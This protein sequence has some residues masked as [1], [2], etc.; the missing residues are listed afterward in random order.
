MNDTHRQFEP[1]TL[2]TLPGGDAGRELRKLHSRSKPMRAKHMTI[3]G[4]LLCVLAPPAWTQSLEI[5]SEQ[6]Y[7]LL[8][9]RQTSTMQYELAEA[10]AEG[11]RVVAGSPISHKEMALLLER[12]AEPPE[13][14]TY[15]LLATTRTSTMQAELNAAA[16]DGFRLLSRTLIAKDRLIGPDELVVVLERPPEVDKHYTYKLLATTRTSTLQDEIGEAA[17]DGYVLAGLAGRSEH[18]VVMEKEIP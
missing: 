7:F 5:D 10:A 9:T 3:L 17:A 15:R 13:T 4:V 12:A 1:R 18:M 8:A 16:L 11:F 6:R 14:Y 2:P